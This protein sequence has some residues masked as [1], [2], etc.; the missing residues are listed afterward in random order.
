M[1]IRHLCRFEKCAHIHTLET[2]SHYC[3]HFH[4]ATTAAISFAFAH[5]HSSTLTITIFFSRV[6]NL[7]F[8]FFLL[9]NRM[10]RSVSNVAN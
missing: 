6:V 7:I 3:I 1:P 8:N 10:L 9:L 5:F 2:R 4:A